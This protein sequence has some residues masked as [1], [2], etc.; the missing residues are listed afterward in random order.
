MRENEEFS[1]K[2]TFYF[3]YQEKMNIKYFIFLGSVRILVLF[4][5]NI[6]INIGDSSSHVMIQLKL[7]LYFFIYTIIDVKY[8]QEKS[9]HI[10]KMMI[11]T[12]LCLNKLLFNTFLGKFMITKL[13]LIYKHRICQK[14]KLTYI[15]NIITPEH[16][17]QEAQSKHKESVEQI[18]EHVQKNQKINAPHQ[19]LIQKIQESDQEIHETQKIQPSKE[20]QEFDQ[21]IQNP[22][23]EIST[24]SKEFAMELLNIL[25]K[26]NL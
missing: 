4:F 3:F 1:I 13:I 6:I 11:I 8:I 23:K 14:L 21:E 5:E 25:N 24:K 9:K 26:E 7:L 17:I 16:K 22:Y 18:Q 2:K 10:Q 20:M 12:E 15:E 19:D